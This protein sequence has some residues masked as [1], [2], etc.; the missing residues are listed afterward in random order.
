MTFAFPP[1]SPY[2][3]TAKTRIAPGAM[4]PEEKEPLFRVPEWIPVP[5]EGALYFVLGALLG[6]FLMLTIVTLMTPLRP[7]M[8]EAATPRTVESGIRHAAITAPQTAPQRAPAAMI[9]PAPPV[10]AQSLPL[11]TAARL[12]SGASRPA[13]RR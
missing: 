6:T 13:L 12:P 4:D 3:T 1:A 8:P 2:A 9:E 5:V 7:A 11:R 10:P